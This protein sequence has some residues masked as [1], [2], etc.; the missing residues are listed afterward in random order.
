MNPHQGFDEYSNNCTRVLDRKY[1]SIKRRE[2]QSNTVKISSILA[3]CSHKG[4]QDKVL[5]K[6]HLA[7]MGQ[8][9]RTIRFLA[10]HPPGT[11]IFRKEKQNWLMKP[12]ESK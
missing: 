10:E 11:A 4:M 2:A 7:G 12:R 1:K 6:F 8:S 5:T 3:P 9:A